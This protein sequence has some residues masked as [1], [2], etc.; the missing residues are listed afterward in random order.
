MVCIVICLVLAWYGG[1]VTLR[2]FTEGR[3]DTRAFDTPRWIVV[4]WIPLAFLMMAIEFA[5]FIARREEFLSYAT[6]G[7]A[8]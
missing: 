3:Q 2:D 5:R 4:M 7:P 8:E 6:T 1:E